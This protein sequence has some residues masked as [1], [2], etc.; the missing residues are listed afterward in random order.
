[1]ATDAGEQVPDFGG[2]SEFF[3]FYDGPQKIAQDVPGGLNGFVGIVGIFA[4]G[5]FALAGCAVG[6][7]FEQEH[8]AQRSFA[9]AGLQ[10]RD[11]GHVDFAQCDFTQAHGGW[12]LWVS[13]S[14]V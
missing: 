9:E 6:V 2:G 3:V 13:V 10:R 11:Q 12:D 1:M 8:A 7:E 5:T 4:G 14:R